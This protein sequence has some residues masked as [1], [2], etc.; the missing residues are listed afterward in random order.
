MSEAVDNALGERL[1]EIRE[2]QHLSTRELSRLS[3][4]TKDTISATE[5]GKRRVRHSTLEKLAKGLGVGIADLIGWHPKGL[6][7]QL[8]KQREETGNYARAR[9]YGLTAMSDEEFAALLDSSSDEELTILKDRMR[10]EQDSLER[11][12][13]LAGESNFRPKWAYGRSGIR[14]LWLTAHMAR[15]E[16]PAMDNAPDEVAIAS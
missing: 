5:R 8:A 1:R 9:G 11:E 10:N 16:R 14:N 3:G 6:L 12:Y 2:A 15:A 4:V 13:A 7:A